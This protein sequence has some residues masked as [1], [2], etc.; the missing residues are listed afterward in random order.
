MFLVD[1]LKKLNEELETLPSNCP[2]ENEEL[3]D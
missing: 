2:I 1:I 3:S